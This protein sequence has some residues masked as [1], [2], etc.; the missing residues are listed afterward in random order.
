MIRYNSCMKEKSFPS[1]ASQSVDCFS[2][3]ML[4]LELTW[5]L[6]SF[7]KQTSE[8]LATIETCYCS[9]L[10]E[11]QFM[12]TDNL[13]KLEAEIAILIWMQGCCIKWPAWSVSPTK[14]PE[15]L[16]I[17]HCSWWLKPEIQE[18]GVTRLGPYPNHYRRQDQVEHY[19]HHRSFYFSQLEVVV[20]TNTSYTRTSEQ[21]FHLS[22]SSH[23]CGPRIAVLPLYPHHFHLYLI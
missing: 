16:V 2:S 5:V 19:L 18:C 4:T 13:Q 7:V 22:S 3:L 12:K 9:V 11:F 6:E 8:E 1:D 20:H 21:S 23:S 10:W 14:K 15:V 17:T